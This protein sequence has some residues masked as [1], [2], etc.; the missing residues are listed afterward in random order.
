MN[1]NPLTYVDPDGHDP[2]LPIIWLAGFNQSD[3]MNY[4]QNQGTTNGCAS[5]S[6]A[7]A[8]NLTLHDPNK[9]QG[10]DVMDRWNRLTYRPFGNGT[11]APWQGE[12]IEEYS[13]YNGINNITADYKSN[14]T[15]S[16]VIDN[17]KAGNPTVLSIS[18]GNDTFGSGIK[19]D[20]GHAVVV[21]GYDPNSGEL[22]FL[23]PAVG[24]L[25]DEDQL[26]GSHA[27][28]IKQWKDQP[29]WFIPSGSMVTVDQ[30]P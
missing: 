10:A 13:R 16:D 19:S 17:L 15:Y 2:Q 22:K 7:M 11:P 12:G 14:G 26:S 20:V 30:T 3:F 23:N 21:V 28:F 24:N 8:I 25:Q 27:D 5:Y 9:V 18:L 6:A 4:V 29:N 1:N